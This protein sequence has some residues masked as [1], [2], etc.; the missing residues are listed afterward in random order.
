[1]NLKSAESVG[2]TMTTV[3]AAAAPV[4]SARRDQDIFM[5][6]L[7]VRTIRSRGVGKRKPHRR[8]RTRRAKEARRLSALLSSAVFLR[9]LGYQIR[10]DCD[11]VGIVEL[12][13]HR[14]HQWRPRAGAGAYLDVV[15]LAIN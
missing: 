4:S 9:P 11:H 3:P 1:M 8:G 12:V 2:L 13:H 6:F 10:R 5:C 15:E 7:R 14:F